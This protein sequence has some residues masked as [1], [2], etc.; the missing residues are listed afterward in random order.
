MIYE[1]INPSDLY[2]FVAE[3]RRVAIVVG[4]LLGRGAYGVTTTDNEREQLLPAMNDIGS[5]AW[6]MAVQLEK[7]HDTNPA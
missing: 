4:L 2:T 5:R 3:D 1:L 7:S 6:E